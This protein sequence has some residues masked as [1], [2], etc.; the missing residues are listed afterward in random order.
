MTA[1]HYLHV[2]TRA[3]GDDG[4]LQY[5]N[6]RM[7]AVFGGIRVRSSSAGF[8]GRL[9]GLQ[10]DRIG[11]YDIGSDE[12]SIEGGG[13]VGQELY[14]LVNLEGRSHVH[15]DGRSRSL[16]GNDAMLI[17]GGLGYGIDL[18]SRHRMVVTRLAGG[19][20]T[21]GLAPYVGRV[22]RAPRTVAIRHLLA[23][24]PRGVGQGIVRPDAVQGTLA[25]LLALDFAEPDLP[26]P[27]RRD[28][29]H[30][31]REG[32][33]EIHRRATT[34]GVGAADIAGALGIGVRQ[35]QAAFAAHG[36]T[37][38]AEV[39]RARLVAV[40]QRLSTDPAEPL[41]TVAHACGFSDQ[42]HLSRCFRAAFGVTPSHYR[43][44]IQ[45]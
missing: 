39:I 22:L 35:L 4:A 13:G 25:T 27:A 32:M 41:T 16:G 23:A 44:R 3:A 26:H 31:W 38:S 6:H 45:G 10:L 24:L 33:R 11:V 42:A 12:A 28:P 30:W 15:Q 7:Q 37:V 20:V 18:E 34:P 19:A 2:S 5:W 21:T 43:A 29:A 1:P 14:L 17:H 40:R 8:H 9:R 36:T